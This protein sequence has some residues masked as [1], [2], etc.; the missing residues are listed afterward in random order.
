MRSRSEGK[1]TMKID[2][3]G[4]R[5]GGGGAAAVVEG[6]NPLVSS[7]ARG[8]DWTGLVNGGLGG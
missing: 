6:A 8:L 2:G 7:L 5:S 4:G 3:G 1:W